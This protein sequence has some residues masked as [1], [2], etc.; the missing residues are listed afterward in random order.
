MCGLPCPGSRCRRPRRICRCGSRRQ[1]PR[2]S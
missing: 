1:A 2:R